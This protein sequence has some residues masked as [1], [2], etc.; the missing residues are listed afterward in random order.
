MAAARTNKQSKIDRTHALFMLCDLSR[1]LVINIIYI[2]SIHAGALLFRGKQKIKIAKE[3]K[4]K[5]IYISFVK[6]VW[7][8]DL[9]MRTSFTYTRMYKHTSSLNPYQHEKRNEARQP[10]CRIELCAI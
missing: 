6:I 9:A 2:A 3:H 10:R 1:V 5:I 7:R 4:M 8:R